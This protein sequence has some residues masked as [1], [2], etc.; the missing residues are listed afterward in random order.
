VR[1]SATHK[2]AWNAT[3][4]LF[5]IGTV[6]LAGAA[7][8]AS[9]LTLVTR[10][11]Q[12][13]ADPVAIERLPAGVATG[14]RRVRMPFLGLPGVGDHGRR[15]TPRCWSNWALC[16]TAGWR[17]SNAHGTVRAYL[18]A[19][20]STASNCRCWARRAVPGIATRAVGHQSAGSGKRHNRRLE[21][22]AAG[23]GSG[24]RLCFLGLPVMSPAYPLRSA[25]ASDTVDW[26][27]RACVCV[28]AVPSA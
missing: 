22:L 4:P 10:D 28:R 6:S 13:W 11:R 23:G 7:A 9:C 3:Q 26:A 12:R 14:H 8:E 25:R 18:A 24:G 17:L 16:K 1:W 21:R 15:P 5:P 19:W 27:E 20:S 2:L